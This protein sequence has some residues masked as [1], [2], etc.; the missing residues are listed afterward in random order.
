MLAANS[1]FNGPSY[2]EYRAEV[3]L[4]DRWRREVAEATLFLARDHFRE[5]ANTAAV[6]RIAVSQTTSDSVD[7][8]NLHVH[9]ATAVVE[10]ALIAFRLDGA[11]LLI[12]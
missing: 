11:G 4:W 6:Q 1:N 3:R 12:S 9:E 8:H 5:K 2:D 10:S 7:L